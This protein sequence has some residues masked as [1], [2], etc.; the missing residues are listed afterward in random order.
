MTQMAQG[1]KLYE[2]KAKIL[3]A[4]DNADQVIQYFKD[5]A[6]AFNAKKKGTIVDK[7]VVNN[8]IA[9]HL[10]QLLE[11]KGIPTHFVKQLSERE[12]LVKRVEII[13]LEVTMRNITAGGMARLLGIE[14]GIVLKTPV[15]EW[16]YKRDDH[17]QRDLQ[18]P[19]LIGPL[20]A[21]GRAGGADPLRQDAR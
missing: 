4:T 16:H 5:D 8:K 12:M 9:S 17:G 13:P 1:E 2:G 6:T 10:F 19:D 3:Y 15:F 21:L 7:G 11:K 20:H 14:E 18:Q